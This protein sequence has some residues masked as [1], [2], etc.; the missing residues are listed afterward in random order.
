MDSLTVSF[1]ANFSTMFPT[2]AP[3]SPIYSGLVTI[4]WS[5]GRHGSY[6]DI[7]LRFEGG[8]TVSEAG[9]DG[10]GDGGE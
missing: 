9:G 1:R 2:G 6:N 3:P 8:M 4:N 7:K 5:E 10:N